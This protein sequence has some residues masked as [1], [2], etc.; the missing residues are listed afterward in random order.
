MKPNL[1]TKFASPA[2]VSAQ[3]SI[4]RG[5]TQLA[6]INKQITVRGGY[7]PTNWLISYPITQPTFLDA[8]GQGRVIFV[9][10]EYQRHHR[11]SQHGG[12]SAHAAKGVAPVG[13]DAGGIIYARNANPTLHNLTMIG[14]NAYY[15]GALYLENSTSTDYR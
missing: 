11:T 7:T 14:G 12:W 4:R 3:S 1:A 6:Y 9:A 10:P 15:G 2:P 8:Q 13:L 5:T